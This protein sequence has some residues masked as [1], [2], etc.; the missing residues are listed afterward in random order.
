MSQIALPLGT[1]TGT[2]TIVVGAALQ[3]LLDALRAASG[4]PFGTAVLTGPPR[5]GKSLFARWFVHEGLGDAL[6][7]ADA[8]PEDALFHRW[9]R[10]QAEGRPLL[11]VSNRPPGTWRIALPDLAS[12]IGAAL[13]LEIPP[14]DEEQ[15]LGLI[16]S[17]AFR[18]GLALPEGAAA[19]LLPRME[20][21][22]AEIEQVIETVDRMSLERKA[23]VTISLLRDALVGRSGQ[24]QP[25][26]L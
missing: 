5:S 24:W 6:D 2:Q 4:W 22:H 16:E 11:I 7:E 18:R 23:A 15:M 17:H 9:N 26:L 25:R 3:P 1:V 12:R 14:P 8:L 21:S 13:L 10:A 20:R 19:Y